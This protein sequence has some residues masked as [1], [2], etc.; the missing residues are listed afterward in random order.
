MTERLGRKTGLFLVLILAASRLFAF[1]INKVP[2]DNWTVPTTS[3]GLT[4]MSVST[5]FIGLTP[6]RIAGTRP[7]DGFSGQYGPPALIAGA[8]RSF[9]LVGQCGIPSGALSVSLNLTVTNTQGPGFILI[10]PAGGSQ[11]TVSTLNYV[12]GQTIANAA[13]VPL[14]SG[15]AVTVVAGVSGTDFIIDTN[16]YFPALL[17]SGDEFDQVGSLPAGLIFAEN[18]SSASFPTSGVRG[19]LTGTGFNAAGILGQASATSGRVHGVMGTTN[20]R[21]VDNSGVYGTDN[22]AVPDPGNVIES[23]GVRGHGQEG[24]VGLTST[25]VTAFGGVCGLMLNS[26]GSLGAFGSLGFSFTTAVQ[27]FGNL[28]ITGT[29]SFAEP[30]PT[31][32]SKMIDYVALEGPEAGTYFRGTGFISDGSFVINVP[33]DFRLVTDSEGLTVQLTPVGAPATMYV[34]SE[35]LNQIIVQSDRDVKFHY[36]V[37]GVRASFK[38]H[39]PIVENTV[40]SPRSAIQ[41]MSGAFAEEQRR[42]L[43]AN[44]TY[45]K[46]GTVNIETAR[47]MGWLQAWEERARQVEDSSKT[48][49]PQS[50]H[51]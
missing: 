32:P 11:P 17:N 36:M 24:V 51:Q 50:K 26:T 8:Q 39:Q 19:F 47:A 34:V 33:E 18:N 9:T 28:S 31:D 23:A 4:T 7:S 46:D 20:S 25:N 49:E 38:N 13:I 3:R 22:S 27:G 44:G 1:D 10:Y 42:R 43:I 29:K 45:N 40:Y 37:N 12:A 15:G 5:P 21:A 16:G 2:P 48:S 35:D 14:G 30:H 41:K 6:C